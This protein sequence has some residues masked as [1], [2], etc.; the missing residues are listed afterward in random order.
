M[1][2]KGL[3]RI[4]KNAFHAWLKDNITLRAAALT[5]FIILPLPTLLLIV[6][7]IFSQFLGPTQAINQ[8]NQ[9]LTAIVG[10]DVANLFSHLL[11]NAES[12]FSSIWTTIFVVGFSFVGAIGTFSVLRDAMNCIWE[13]RLP[14]KQPFWKMLRQKLGPFIL[15]SV[16]GLI[17]FFWTAVASGF[18]DLI[19]FI[20][21]DRTLT[22]VLNTIVQV[23][24]SFFVSTISLALIYKLIPEAKVQ[25][26]DVVLAAVTTG[27]AFS[28]INFVFGTYIKTFTIT[29]II[30]AAGSLLIILLWLFI[31]N[32]L[33]LFGAEISKI[34]A[35]TFG[36]YSEQHFPAPLDKIVEPI[37]KVV[38]RIEQATKD[39]Y[40]TD[41]KE[42]VD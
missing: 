37:E 15:F 28:V 38:E 17:V 2:W 23:V 36:L 29:T 9:Q 13:V 18:F 22:T 14:K 27:I 33:V 7:A 25:W 3:L 19:I 20:S 10:P 32:E 1:N 40:E 26:S 41:P 11:S 6:L 12:P 24:F 5:F 4:Y 8:L 21:I 34:S 16:L 39:E 35:S 30:G 31:L 42:G